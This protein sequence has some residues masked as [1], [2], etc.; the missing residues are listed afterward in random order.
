MTK[1]R[2]LL[3]NWPRGTLRL[4]KELER[5]GIGR[6]LLASYKESGWVESFD[7]GVYKHA[8]D[9][10]DWLGA[11]YALQ[12]VKGSTLHPGGK[13]AL[14]LKGYSHYIG[15]GNETRFLYMHHL[16]GNYRWLSKFETVERVQTNV[17]NYH[18][19]EYFSRYSTGTFDIYVSVPELAV[20]EMLYLTPNKQSF[21]EAGKII[22]LLY[23]LRPELLQRLLQECRSVKVVRLLLFFA[24]YYDH[25]W[26]KE[27]DQS[28]LNLGS[29]NRVI[30]QD[31][32]FSP[33]YQITVPR[34]YGYDTV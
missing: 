24:D 8:K 32:I 31:G 34:D 14:A 11:V 10:V 5:S 1:L 27:L 4:T 30:V 15:M 29:G 13:T 21:D 12:Q 23:S 9:K 26:L 18:K 33:K 16:D 22:E 7:H 19:T 2:R 6:Q 17:F 28:K 25:P 3:S 20:L